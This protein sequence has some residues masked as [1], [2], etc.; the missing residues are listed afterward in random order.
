MPLFYSHTS[1]VPDLTGFSFHKMLYDVDFDGVV[2]PGLCGAFY[3][4]REGDRVLSVGMYL[5][6]GWELF[7]A[8][9]HVDE[10]RCA[11]HAVR[12]DS[13][14][15]DGAHRGCP[16]VRVER[17]AGSVS[18]VTVNTRHAEHRTAVRPRP[19]ATF[20]ES[21]VGRERSCAAVKSG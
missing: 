10:K 6:D 8:W 21:A 7:R 18:V 14:E 9:G 4:R 11:W 15:F 19:G 1:E 17:R 5:A 12:A 3:R 13:G 16:Q 2:V 20:G